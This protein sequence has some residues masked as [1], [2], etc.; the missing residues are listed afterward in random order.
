MSW[1]GYWGNRIKLSIDNSKIDADLTDFPVL[2]RLSS[3]AGITGADVSFIFDEVGATSKKIAIATSNAVQCPIE[4]EKWSSPTEAIL[5]TKIPTV[6][7]GVATDLYFY[8]DANQPDNTDYVGDIESIPGEDVWDSDFLEVHHMCQ[9]SSPTKDS[10]FNDY[11]STWFNGP[12]RGS[13]KI[14]YGMV[15][16]GSNDY[17]DSS[18]NVVANGTATFEGWYNITQT[19][20][21][22]GT[23]IHL[24]YHYYIHTVNDY[25]YFI[26]TSDLFLSKIETGWTYIAIKYDGDTSTARMCHDG[27][28]FDC[29]QQPAAHDIDVWNGTIGRNANSFYG[30]MDEVRVSTVPR[31][32]EWLKASYYSGD[33][34]LITFDT[35]VEVPPL[36]VFSNIWTREP[37]IFRATFSGVN[38]Y[39]STTEALLDTVNLRWGAN[40][41]WANDN[42]L[43]IAS[44]ISG[45]LWLPLNTITGAGDLT[46]QLSIYRAFPDLTDNYVNYLHGGGNYLCATTASGVDHINMITNSGIYTLISTAHKCYQTENGRF[47]YESGDELD[48]VYD[49]ANNWVNPDYAYLVGGGI[50]PTGVTIN[51]FFITEGTSA[52]QSTDNVI[53]LATTNGVVVIEE[54]KNDEANSR[55]KYFYI[56]P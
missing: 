36:A 5:W 3:S 49:N 13:S 14:G 40:S 54:R 53:F 18:A 30:R 23:N 29:V 21:D 34:N 7:S 22:K 10:T 50:I 6:T 41:V 20:G 33:D 4:I 48:V 47:Y 39:D 35:T 9:S 42:Y 16:D 2:I 15:F 38:V 45:I 32:D 28:F 51:D 25:I 8:F 56:E 55:S 31:E 24:F 43:F 1:L 17:I 44:T 19:A 12:Y 11:D 27:V 37:Y 52:Y 26:G 46:D